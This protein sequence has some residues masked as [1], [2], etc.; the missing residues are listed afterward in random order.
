LVAAA[1]SVAACQSPTSA[2][3]NSTMTMTF[4]PDPVT[5]TPSSGVSYTIKNANK[6]DETHDYQ[7]ATTFAVTLKNTDTVGVT[8]SSLII[9]VQQASGGIVVVP[10]T[11]DTEYYTFTS[12]PNSNRVEANNGTET[13]QFNVWYSLPNQGQ[14]AIITVS[15]TVTKDDNSGSFSSQGSLHVVP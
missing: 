4:S 10:T 6:P 1:L 12:S 9:K 13:S 5:A 14:E 7:Y 2:S 3:S 15:Y 8:I 11:G